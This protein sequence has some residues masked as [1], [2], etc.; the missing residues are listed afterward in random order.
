MSFKWLGIRFLLM[1][2]RIQ[3]SSDVHW[4]NTIELIA[5]FV[6]GVISYLADRLLSNNPTKWYFSLEKP[7]KSD[8]T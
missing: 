2:L 7:A 4:Q 5:R 3:L 8:K 6:W 1:R